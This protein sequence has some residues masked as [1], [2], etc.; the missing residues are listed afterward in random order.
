MAPRC[1]R[2]QSAE[3]AHPPPQRIAPGRPAGRDSETPGPG[4]THPWRRP[5]RNLTRQGTFARQAEQCTCR[6]RSHRHSLNN[7][8]EL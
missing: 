6:T 8:C 3:T 5:A 2:P 4:N 7:Q 1:R